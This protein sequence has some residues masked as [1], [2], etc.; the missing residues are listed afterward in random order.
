MFPGRN[1]PCE[2]HSVMKLREKTFEEKIILRPTR[3]AVWANVV[4]AYYN[5]I[6]TADRIMSLILLQNAENMEKSTPTFS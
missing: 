6:S 2:V 3:K 4:S 1:S 5:K